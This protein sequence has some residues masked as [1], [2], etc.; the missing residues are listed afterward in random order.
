MMQNFSQNL[1]ENNIYDDIIF[2]NLLVGYTGLGSVVLI[3]FIHMYS[4]Y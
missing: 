1:L 4:K 2:F 3:L